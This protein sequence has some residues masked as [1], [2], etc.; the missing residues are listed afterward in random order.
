MLVSVLL[1]ESEYHLLRKRAG[2]GSGVVPFSS[3]QTVGHN[4]AWREV[5]FAS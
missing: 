3:Q 4:L 1:S 5:E 2:T